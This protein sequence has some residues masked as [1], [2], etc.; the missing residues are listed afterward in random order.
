V[1]VSKLLSLKETIFIFA[2]W[3]SQ[4]IF[5]IIYICRICVLAAVHNVKA[6]DGRDT[7]RGVI[8]ILDF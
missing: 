5:G 1:T 2:F 3:H 8:I 6:D 7:F 4:N